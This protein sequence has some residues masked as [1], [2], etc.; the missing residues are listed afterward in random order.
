MG[1]KRTS[2][3]TGPTSRRT[4]TYNNSNG[5]VTNSTSSGSKNFRTTVSNNSKT[6]QKITQTWRDGGGFTHRKTLYKSPTAASMKKQQREAQK[7]W[8]WLG[9][10]SKKKSA[11]K[12]KSADSYGFGILFLIVIGITVLFGK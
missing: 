9:G 11:P 2:K 12:K 6:G 3:K 7:F 1:Y 5:S 4:T 8:A 10:N